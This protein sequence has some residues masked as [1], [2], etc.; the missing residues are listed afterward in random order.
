[1]QKWD[2]Y[3]VDVKQGLKLNVCLVPLVCSFLF[4]S[5]L[6]EK[7]RGRYW[8]T[9]EGRGQ[10]L[11]N[12]GGG[13]GR[14]WW[15]WEGRG[16]YWWTWEG[17]GQILVGRGREYW[18]TWEDDIGELGGGGG[19]WIRHQRGW[20]LAAVQ[21]SQSKGMTQRWAKGQ[22]G[23]RMLAHSVLWSTKNLCYC[24]SEACPFELLC[25]QSLCTC[26]PTLNWLISLCWHMA[27][28]WPARQATPSTTHKE[29]SLPP[30]IPCSS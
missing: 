25:V 8:W 1:M 29:Q 5:F 26:P 17:R 4:W 9:W 27:T 20:P 13:G 14:Y 12:L 30:S 24:S 6:L 11:V 23:G 10:I 21:L 22:P 19:G 28:E 3:G 2:L 18:W 16:R 15:T 7:G